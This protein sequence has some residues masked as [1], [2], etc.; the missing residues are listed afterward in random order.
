MKDIR[1]DTPSKTLSGKFA[2]AKFTNTENGVDIFTLG[3]RTILSIPGKDTVDFSTE[4]FKSR[5]DIMLS[6]FAQNNGVASPTV[7]QAPSTTLRSSTLPTGSKSEPR[8]VGDR[9][10]R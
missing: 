10:K 6:Q 5:R 8:I 7:A 9:L 3:D 1:L 4:I 2:E